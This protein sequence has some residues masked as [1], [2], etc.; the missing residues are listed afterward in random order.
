MIAVL[1]VDT[2]AAVTV[3]ALTDI[4]RV[5]VAAPAVIVVEAAQEVAAL[6]VAT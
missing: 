1:V 2:V 6:A 3:E 4:V 5:P